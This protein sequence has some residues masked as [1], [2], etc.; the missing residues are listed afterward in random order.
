MTQ[1]YRHKEIY[2]T[3][4]PNNKGSA[5]GPGSSK[6]W[7]LEDGGILCEGVVMDDGR[8]FVVE[9]LSKKPLL[10]NEK[11]VHERRSLYVGCYTLY[12]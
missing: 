7:I 1:F 10:I 2:C 5:D 11:H 6:V 8:L 9:G 4:S 12:H 3:Y